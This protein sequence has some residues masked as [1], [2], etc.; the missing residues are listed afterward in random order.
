MSNLTQFSCSKFWGFENTKILSLKEI[1]TNETDDKNAFSETIMNKKFESIF[2]NQL[3]Q[4]FTSRGECLAIT[5]FFKFPIANT[6]IFITPY[7]YCS[8]ISGAIF[9]FTYIESHPAIHHRQLADAF[10]K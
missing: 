1:Q 4:D 6:E 10:S 8:S 5:D 2:L 9:I 7:S 3:K